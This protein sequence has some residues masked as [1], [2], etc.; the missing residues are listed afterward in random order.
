MQNKVSHREKQTSYINAYIWNL[1]KILLNLFA[2]KDW[3]H[4]C[5]DTA[6]E[7]EGGLN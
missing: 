6:G 7:R 1:E 3:R 4:R 5:R 2:E